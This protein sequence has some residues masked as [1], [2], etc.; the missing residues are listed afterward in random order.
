MV[1][2]E[3]L[4]PPP[5]RIGRARVLPKGVLWIIKDRPMAIDRF[6]WPDKDASR[7][8]DAIAGRLV[9]CAGA[10]VKHEYLVV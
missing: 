6:V 4:P 1:P 10:F 9:Q 5:F 8:S 2:L 7:S 3:V